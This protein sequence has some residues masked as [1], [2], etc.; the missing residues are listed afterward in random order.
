METDA[1]KVGPA[2]DHGDDR[3]ATQTRT[4]SQNTTSFSQYPIVKEHEVVGPPT[5]GRPLHTPHGSAGSGGEG[6][7]GERK[8]GQPSRYKIRLV[9]LLESLGQVLEV[10]LWLRGCRLR[11][12]LLGGCR[13]GGRLLGG[14]LLGHNLVEGRKNGENATPWHEHIERT[15]GRGERGSLGQQTGSFCLVCVLSCSK[16]WCCATLL[17]RRRP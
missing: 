12:G 15:G 7:G 10:T 3:G 9:V 2:R 14:R 13:L 5:I 4:Q 1:T 17:D 8:G 11:G 16:L 6:G